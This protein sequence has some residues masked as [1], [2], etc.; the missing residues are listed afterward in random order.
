LDLV[1]PF[2]LAAAAI[3]EFVAEVDFPFAIL[4]E[5]AFLLLQFLSQRHSASRPVSSV[6]V[7]DVICCFT[8]P[9][10]QESL[11]CRG[12][13]HNIIARRWQGYA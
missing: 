5:E 6:T 3:A 2:D 10:A 8:P 9:E 11:A 12:S 4:A 1:R 7:T 13:F